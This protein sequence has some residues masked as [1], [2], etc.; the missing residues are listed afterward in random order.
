MSLK[1]GHAPFCAYD[2]LAEKLFE[3][4]LFCRP[5]LEKICLVTPPSRNGKKDHAFLLA[6]R[7]SNKMQVPMGPKL[8]HVRSDLGRHQRQK[9]KRERREIVFE[10][11]KDSRVMQ[12][13]ENYFF[14]DDVITT[15][16]TALAA[17][18]ALGSPKNFE[19][20][21]LARRLL[22]GSKPL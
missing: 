17:W 20:L 1:G 18:R 9:N 3:Q 4:R 12:G 14:V 21:T 11:C 10:V 13:A 2:F 8:I 6:E 16:G 22:A 5:L 19:I 7:L 15:G